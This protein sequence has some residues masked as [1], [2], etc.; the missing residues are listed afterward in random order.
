[1]SDFSLSSEFKIEATIRI[2]AKGS[3]APLTG[4]AYKVRLFDKDTFDDDYLGESS[5]DPNGVARIAFTHDA[6][7]DLAGI[8]AK[9]DF[10]FV[11]V[12]N[13][14]Q[15][16]QSKVMEEVDLEA[17]EQFKMGKGEVIDLGTFL[18]EG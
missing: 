10:Y 15:I 9:P 2:I 11:L 18:V 5:L 16:F 4:D 14:V 3:D 6:F 7:D 17:V 1:M 8:E 12:K 13:D